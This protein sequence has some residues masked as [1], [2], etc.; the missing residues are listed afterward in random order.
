MVTS[1]WNQSNFC[2]N[3]IV[4]KALLRCGSLVFCDVVIDIKYNTTT[5][6]RATH[7]PSIPRLYRF[8]NLWG[9]PMQKMYQ[10]RIV[11]GEICHAYLPIKTKTLL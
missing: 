7:L 11:L 5:N 10:A 2:G 9:M 6:L 4:T 1:R 3:I 8:Q